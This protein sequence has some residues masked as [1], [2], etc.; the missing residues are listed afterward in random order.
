MFEVINRTAP[1][2]I[3]KCPPP[4]WW[5][6]DSFPIQSSI[7]RAVPAPAAN[8]GPP[9][10]TSATMMVL[11]VPS[12]ISSIRSPLS[13]PMIPRVLPDP[14]VEPAPVMAT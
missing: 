5:L 12:T 6:H 13:N 7:R 2:A 14:C 9:S 4:T 10:V 11:L 3:R 8:Q 1:S